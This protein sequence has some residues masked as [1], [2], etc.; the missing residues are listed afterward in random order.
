MSDLIK[1][2]D[3]GLKCDNPTCDWTDTSLKFADYEKHINMSCPK[4]G[5]NVLTEEDNNNMKEFM[6]YVALINKYPELRK[7]Y[8][9]GI[10]AQLI[11]A[12]IDPDEKVRA[13]FN[14]HKTITLDRIELKN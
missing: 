14:T 9:A 8:K 2:I 1:F 11:S 12:G 6:Q 4:C 13:V 10:Q 3:G 5:E 7:E